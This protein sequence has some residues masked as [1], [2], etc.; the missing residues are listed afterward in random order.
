MPLE[1]GTLLP[2]S[3]LRWG[4]RVSQK[5]SKPEIYIHKPYT[6]T[7]DMKDAEKRVMKESLGL[8]PD[9]DS[10]L[11]EEDAVWDPLSEFVEDAVEP[12]I[13]IPNLN[14]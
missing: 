6:Y 3:R 5:R 11:E 2:L 10:D 13:R 4:T 12:E 9:E 1:R 7:Q 8:D 14:P